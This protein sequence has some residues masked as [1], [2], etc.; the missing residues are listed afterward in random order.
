M[1]GSNF[2]LLVKKFSR[3]KIGLIFFILLALMYLI[4]I[5]SGFIAP[6]SSGAPYANQNKE[7]F[8]YYKG[9]SLHMPTPINYIV[10]KNGKGKIYVKEY[11]REDKPGY[12][13][14]IPM[15]LKRTL[16]ELMDFIKSDAVESIINNYPTKGNKPTYIIEL[17]NKLSGKNKAEFIKL[18]NASQV[19]KQY[20]SEIVINT[21]DDKLRA[22]AAKVVISKYFSSFDQFS[23]I[24]SG[25]KREEK[26]TDEKLREIYSTNFQSKD[27]IKVAN[28]IIRQKEGMVLS[29]ILRFLGVGDINKGV[30]LKR[31]V[32]IFDEVLS[33]MDKK[34][35][36]NIF[37]TTRTYKLKGDIGFSGKLLRFEKLITAYEK[38]KEKHDVEENYFEE[39]LALYNE[40][41]KSK[42]SSIIKEAII[43]YLGLKTISD[44]FENYYKNIKDSEY[45]KDLPES[46]QK[47][48]VD[49]YEEE[50][51]KRLREKNY[52]RVKDKLPEDF[53]KVIE[54][55]QFDE[56]VPDDT[57]SNYN[58]AVIETDYFKSLSKIEQAE[59]TAA[60]GEIDFKI[61]REIYSLV[62]NEL[63]ELFVDIIESSGLEINVKN[64]PVNDL[65]D[66]VRSTDYFANLPDEIKNNFKNTY[67]NDI[68][69]AGDPL[70][71]QNYNKIKEELEPRFREIVEYSPKY[72]VTV[73]KGLIL[74]TPHYIMKEW[75]DKYIANEIPKDIYNSKYTEVKDKLPKEI[76][77]L[78]IDF[79]NTDFTVR[80]FFEYI[81]PNLKELV[82]NNDYTS[83][84]SRDD[85]QNTVVTKDLLKRI[86]NSIAEIFH[87]YLDFSGKTVKEIFQLIPY[88]SKNRKVPTL[89]SIIKQKH[90]NL[91]GNKAY[92]PPLELLKED[93]EY[94]IDYFNYYVEQERLHYEHKL[95]WFVK[96]EE[97]T[98]FWV[99]KTNIHL[100]GTEDHK[101]FYLMGADKQGR[102]IFSRIIHGGIISLTVGFLGMFLSLTIAITIGG[103]AGFF[104]GM[105]DWIVMRIC[106]IVMLFPSFYLLLTLRGVLPTD[107]SPEQ[108]FILIIIILSFMQWAGTARVIRGF[109]LSGKNQDFVIAAKIA[110][111][112]TPLVIL[113]HLLPQIS[114]YLIVTASIG[115]PGYIIYE[116]SLS[117][118]GFGISEPSV[119][120]GLML[121]GLRESSIETVVFDYPW[122][123][124]PVAFVALAIMCFQ[125]IGDAIRDTLDPMVKR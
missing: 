103:L 11:I 58:K 62:K 104:G 14:Y 18:V 112:P 72:L 78:I 54:N 75:V 27:G 41:L 74:N 31:K 119:S 5:L 35:K 19:Q 65:Y 73:G 114:S 1:E 10:G 45:F 117:W 80:E 77:N 82:P 16:K 49:V 67:T 13:K 40:L 109:I 29:Q 43:E 99:F 48:F 102:C 113:K 30:S 81:I 111:I 42:D 56:K 17:I 38:L 32:I 61:K 68:K 97:Y 36:K 91:L 12:S 70:K 53:T 122:L 37:I 64:H 50:Y 107:M 46:E 93:N 85:L 115:I 95:G 79:Q 88:T 71:E 7:L 108:R 101:A 23:S 90:I 92:V 84:N 9:K 4:V 39:D 125:L 110:G 100:F 76:V 96:G 44:T 118:L 124:W 55:P 33:K 89:G 20:I 28:E 121:S 15:E 123:L 26:F 47:Y 3:Y 21:I 2:S 87:K 83:L 34:F 51:G 69:K 52:L 60:Y 25:L 86:P 106:E 22:R 57:V 105:V 94:F 59:Y 66:I 6:Y 8:D 116:T 120:W 24:V 63:P 98:L